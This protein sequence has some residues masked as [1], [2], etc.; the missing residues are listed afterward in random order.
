MA[1]DRTFVEN[2]ELSVRTVNVLKNNGITTAEQF[3]KLTKTQVMGLK[4]LGAKSWRE[5]SEVQ[6]MLTRERRRESI[7]G[8]AVELIKAL[9]RLVPDLTK[10][11]F[12]LTLCSDPPQLRL[13][14]YA[15]KGDL[16]G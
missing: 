9:N 15:T 13:G 1:F 6:E 14:R 10:H 4:G 5:I 11:R 2:L 3:M 7:P 8:Q 16:D 12:F